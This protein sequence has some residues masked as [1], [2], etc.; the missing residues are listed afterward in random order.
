MWGYCVSSAA[1]FITLKMVEYRPH[2]RASVTRAIHASAL[3]LEYRFQIYDSTWWKFARDT[4]GFFW[5][6]VSTPLYK[7]PISI[8]NLPWSY[9]YTNFRYMVTARFG[10]LHTHLPQRIGEILNV[11][12]L[13]R[14]VLVRMMQVGFYLFENSRVCSISNEISGFS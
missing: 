6:V 12:F 3:Y 4:I 11:Q 7:A 14:W 9:N 5:L 2:N 1:T 10:I 8:S 13:G